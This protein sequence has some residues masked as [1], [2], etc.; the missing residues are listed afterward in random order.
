MQESIL[1]ESKET[2]T[3]LTHPGLTLSL[4]VGG[5]RGIGTGGKDMET[6]ERE[7]WRCG[8]VYGIKEDDCP[9]CHAAIDESTILSS[10]G[11]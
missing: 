11:H 1:A 9:S 5:G 10:P 6:Y 2:L 4:G 3:A 8:L 7:C